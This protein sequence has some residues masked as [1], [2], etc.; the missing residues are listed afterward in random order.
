MTCVLH[1]TRISNALNVMCGDKY[2]KIVNFKLGSEMMNMRSLLCD[3]RATKK[4]E[5]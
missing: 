3:E 1:T 4:I 5:F 2:G